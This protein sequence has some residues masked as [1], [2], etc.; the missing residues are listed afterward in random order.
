MI[1]SYIQLK[2]KIKN[3]AH[4]DSNISQAYLRNYILERFLERVS[5]SAYKNNFI[6]KG[7][8]LVAS[9]TN[10]DIRA[11]RDIDATIQAITLDPNEIRDI[12][13]KIILIDVND[14]V[15]FE[16]ISINSIM[17]EKIYPGIRCNLTAT[18]GRIKQKISIDF[19]TGDIITPSAVEYKYKLMFEDRYISL[20]TY[21]LETLIAE[22]LES[23]VSKGL[24]NT[25]M[26]DYYDLYIITNNSQI[27]I[28]Y[29]VL[30][31]A[32]SATC[33]ARRTD[34]SIKNIKNVITDIAKD[35]SLNKYWDRYI[36]NTHYAQ[37]I[38]WEDIM[39]NLNTIISKMEETD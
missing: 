33:K 14:N 38:I 35:N 19:S 18:F 30:H 27:Q 32:F 4:G 17:H 3:K 26:R 36:N 10:L 24:A 7:G 31:K 39:E 15:V 20:M 37:E 12:V 1:D 9:F 25:R 34:Y 28:D 5:F 29:Y 23:I 16:L 13:N 21:N 8:I 22:K 6:L 11:T 2:A